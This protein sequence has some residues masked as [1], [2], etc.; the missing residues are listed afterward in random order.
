MFLNSIVSMISSNLINTISKQVIRIGYMNKSLEKLFLPTI[1]TLEP[2]R[3]A[4]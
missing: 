3:D 1:F 2:K 4:A